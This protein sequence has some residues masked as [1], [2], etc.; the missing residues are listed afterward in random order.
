MY[1]TMNLNNFKIHVVYPFIPSFSLSLIVSYANQHVKKFAY[2]Q[3]PEKPWL[4]PPSSLL[5]TDRSKAVV[6]V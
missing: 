4:K 5:A 1:H 6:L 2:E 3:H